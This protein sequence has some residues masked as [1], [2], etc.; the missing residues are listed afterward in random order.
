MNKR[1]YLPPNIYVRYDY[2]EDWENH[3]RQLHP[4]FKLA[5]SKEYKG[6]C[7]LRKDRLM[8]D[9]KE[10]TTTIRNNVRELFQYLQPRNTVEKQNDNILCS[11]GSHIVF[12]NLQKAPFQVK[13]TQ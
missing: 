1:Q 7:F 4:I 2:P 8:I 10:F 3:R 5:K 13:C 12:S 6:K 11:L 9:G